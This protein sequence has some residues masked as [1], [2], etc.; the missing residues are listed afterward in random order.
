MGKILDII[1]YFYFQKDNNL[2]PFIEVLDS[3]YD[4]LEK[5]ISGI[6][7]L[8]NV[9]KCPDDKLVYLAALTGCPLIGNDTL[10]WRRQIKNWPHILK[11]KGTQKSLELVLDSVGADSWDIKTFFR[12]AGG[13]YVTHKPDGKPFLDNSGLWC[14]IR[15]HYFGVQLTLSKNFVEK[16]DFNW[17]VQEVKEKVNYRHL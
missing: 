13:G 1:P 5:K 11:L 16:H 12:D 6:T 7:D 10:F 15:T 2:A 9:D 3:E 8:I 4:E 17:D 14:N